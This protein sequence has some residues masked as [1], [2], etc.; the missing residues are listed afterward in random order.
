MPESSSQDARNAADTT[1][2]ANDQGGESPTSQASFL[3]LKRSGSDP[4]IVELSIDT[5]AL[6]PPTLEFYAHCCA[7][8]ALA[9]GTHMVFAQVD[10]TRPSAP[11]N[12]ICISMNAVMA[13][14][15]H[16]SF[17]SQ[18]REILVRA[19]GSDTTPLPYP[20]TPLETPITVLG[21]SVAVSRL[22]PTGSTIDFY[23]VAD[24]SGNL[25]P[26]PVNSVLRVLCN[27][28]VVA[29]LIDGL[30]AIASLRSRP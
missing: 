16:D 1:M 8:R 5:G 15:F 29:Q 24:V 17:G 22:N 6:R 12:A 26:V 10:P 11:A 20:A 2:S 27:E 14:Q 9:G 19:L 18:F 21:A 3:P 23:A 25:N 13:R 30:D 7:V 28:P 4:N